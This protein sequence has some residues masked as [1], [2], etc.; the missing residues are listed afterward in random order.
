MAR[1]KKGLISR[2][3]YRRVGTRLIIVTLS[4]KE[5]ERLKF[6]GKYQIKKPHGGQNLY[7]YIWR[8]FGETKFDLTL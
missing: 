7:N 4:I 6:F 2:R 8:S 5:T 1:K 3:K